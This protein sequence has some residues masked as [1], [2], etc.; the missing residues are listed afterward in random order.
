VFEGNALT[1]IGDYTFIDCHGLATITLPE[2]LVSIGTECF[3]D[4][5]AITSL[6]TPASLKTIGD[7]AFYNC[8]G[9]D[10]EGALVLSD[11]IEEIGEF[12]FTGINK[13]NITAPE[14]SFAAEYV[15]N[16]RATEEETE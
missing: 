2:G 14:D 3:R 11:S 16:M 15:N 8:E 6:T 12:A 13:L 4:C 1:S 5:T 9:L 10:A 7:M